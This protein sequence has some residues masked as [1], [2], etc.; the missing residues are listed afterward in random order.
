[1]TPIPLQVVLLIAV[2]ISQIFGGISCCCLGI[3]LVADLNIASNAT[4]S[5][6]VSPQE[7]SSV[8]QTRQTGKCS[9]CWA[10]KSNSTVTEKTSS[11]RLHDH[12][13]KV[14]QDVECRCVKLAV[15]A[16]TSSSPPLL[17]HDSHA[18]VSPALGVNPEREVL[19]HILAKY[20]VPA[21][22]GGRSWQSI[23]CLWNN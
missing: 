14:C 8:L 22:F 15:K 9:K 6:L 4:A 21:R 11:H 5:E 20:D 10:K 18:W 3:T 19:T 2:A 12:H 13:V 23:A 17:S 1:M 16:S 7:S